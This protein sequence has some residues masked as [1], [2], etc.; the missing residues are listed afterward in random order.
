MITGGLVTKVRLLR[1]ELDVDDDRVGV[2][3]HAEKDVSGL[4]AKH[5]R[6]TNRQARYLR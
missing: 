6:G 1:V 5:N 4:F 3:R 2:V